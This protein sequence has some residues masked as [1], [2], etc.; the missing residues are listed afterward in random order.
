MSAAGQKVWGSIGTPLEHGEP[1][2]SGTK[3]HFPPIG[4]IQHWVQARLHIEDPK[5]AK[6]VAYAIAVTISKRGTK[7]KKMFK[8]GVDENKA[9]AKRILAQ[10]PADIIRRVNQ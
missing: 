10:I 4:P 2:E 5:K 1:V 9:L 3:P 8:T 7:G 6:S